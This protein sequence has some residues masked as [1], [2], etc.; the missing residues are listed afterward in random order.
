M[1]PMNVAVVSAKIV[2]DK[3]HPVSAVSAPCPV[4]HLQLEFP[5]Q[6]LSD[7]WE[8]ARDEALKYPNIC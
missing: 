8:A 1:E 7:I 3:V 2:G 5:H 4:I 6:G